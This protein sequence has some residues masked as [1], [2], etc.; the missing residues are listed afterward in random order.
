MHA[1]LPDILVASTSLLEN[2]LT[3]EEAQIVREAAD[4]ANKFEMELWDEAA[5]EAK[6]KAEAMGVKFYYPD[7]KPFQEKMS[8]L[9]AEYT[10]D[11]DMKAVYD[12]IRKKG[13]E[14]LAKNASIESKEE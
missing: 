7:I 14:I 8:A 11:E 2:K 6:E 4:Y 3:K 5:Q 13:D 1:M 12:K 9:H 10:Q